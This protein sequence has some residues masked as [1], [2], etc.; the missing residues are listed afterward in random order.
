M[1]KTKLNIPAVLVHDIKG[2]QYKVNGILLAIN[3][4]NDT[5]TMKFDGNLVESNIPMNKILINEG[6]LDKVKEYGKKVTSYITSKVKGFIAL[7]DEATGKVFPWS[8]CNV[9]NLAIKAAKGDMPDGVFFAPS[10]SLQKIAGVKG[11]TI[12]QAFAAAE[13]IE[14][15]QIINYW[16]RVIKRTGTT[17]NESI[18]ESIKYVNETY[19]KESKMYKKLNEVVYSYDDVKMGK[20]NG[21]AG[22]FGVPVSSK[23]LKAK[24]KTN[25]LNQI[26]G[27]LGGHADVVP[28]LIWGAPGI[29]KTAIIKSTIKDMAQSKWHAINL[30]LEIIS[31]SGYTI[32]QWTLPSGY[33]RNIAGIEIDRFAD[34]PKIWLPVYLR[35]SDPEENARRDDFCNTCK[36]L[37][38]NPEGHITSADG[39]PFE[40]GIV[41]MD[42][43][44]RVEPNVQNI[45]M[46][47]GNEHTFGDN[48]QVA[49]KWGFVFASNRSFDEND[50]E[51]DDLRYFPTAAQMNRFKHFTY[52]PSKKE[53]IEWAREVNPITHEANVPPF[54]TDFIEASE[55]FVWYSTIVNGGYDD[56]LENPEVNKRAHEHDESEVQ[57]VL[58]QPLLKT[59]RIVTPRTWANTIGPEYKMELIRIFDGNKEGMTGKEYYQKLIDD[60]IIEKTDEEGNSYKEY[61][62]GILPNILIDA[63]NDVD[64][65]CWEEWVED[66]GGEEYLDPSGSFTGIRGRYNMFMQWVLENIRDTTGDGSGTNA[67]NSTSP[68]IQQWKS[69]QSYAKYFTPDVYLSIWKTGKMPKEYQKDDDKKPVSV[70]KFADTEFSKWKQ[71]SSICFDVAKGLFDAYPGDLAE[72]VEH[73]IQNM[74]KA[75]P[76][77]PEDITIEAEK[78]IDEYS[79][80]LNNKKVNLLFDAKDLADHERLANMIFSLKNS[81]VAQRFAHFAQWISKVAI[82]AE[83]GHLAGDYENKLLNV[84]LGLDTDLQRTFTNHEKVSST[85]KASM[86]N[87][88]DKSIQRQY[89]IETSKI[90]IMPAM[91]MLHRAKEFDFNN[92]RNVRAKNK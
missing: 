63:L 12:D 68:V 23:Q 35:S 57:A 17:P 82:Q 27:P 66:K 86:K 25:I 71:V 76:I 58:D 83:N 50:A 84:I 11:M 72:D 51:T 60:S 43:Y 39:H 36:F 30:N 34:K 33:I 24:L 29:G 21:G 22:Q 89:K 5:C 90:P 44:S 15:E 69:Y 40:G 78:L 92:V 48:Y 67:Y 6:F 55:D 77:K 9:A 87:P 52:V 28:F 19:Y 70:D 38:T 62:G 54:I 41:F 7:V 1:V 79:F 18:K 45:L 32:E 10:P 75:T 74:A 4:S 85:K 91:T 2:T 88:K 46:A 59:K 53:W 80:M 8:M 56:L 26:S 73:D 65:E 37:A 14:R 42:E 47:L 20:K 16:T 61:Y 3:E 31:L 81:V 49:S 64:D 13:S